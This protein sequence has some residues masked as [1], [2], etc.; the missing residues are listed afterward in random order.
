MTCQALWILRGTMG[1]STPQCKPREDGR[2]PFCHC[3]GAR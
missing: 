3:G 1:E 2:C